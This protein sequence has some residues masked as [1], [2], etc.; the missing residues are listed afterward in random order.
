MAVLESLLHHTVGLSRLSHVLHPA[1]LES[2]E[3]VR[4]ILH[5]ARLARLHARLSSCCTRLGGQHGLVQ[6]QPLSPLR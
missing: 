5:P 2:C 6:R 3:G 1:P 4:G